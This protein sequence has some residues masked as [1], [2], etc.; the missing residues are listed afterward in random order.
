MFSLDVVDTDK[1]LDMPVSAQALYFHLGM[2][3]D[4]DGF[5]SSPRKITSLVG[6]NADDLKILVSKQFIIPF[7]SGII[8]IAD[9]RVN[10]Y[11]RSDR[12]KGTR[13]IGELEQLSCRDGNY[14]LD[15]IGIPDADQMETQGRID[16]GRID[17]S[18]D[19]SLLCNFQSENYPEESTKLIMPYA[20][21]QSLYNKICISF[22]RLTKMSE[23]RKKAIRARMKIYSLDDFR[24]LF[25]NAEASVFLKGGNNRNWVAT[26]DW[27]IKDSNFAKTLEGNYRNRI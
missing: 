1:F 19:K 25:E 14:S 21:I 10:N 8:V 6:S 7:E 18:K 5:V 20:E 16:Q 2:R 15:T 23:S 12:Y 27:L 26:F 22:P 4:D 13:Y 17:K 11:L 3:A 24:K 9:W